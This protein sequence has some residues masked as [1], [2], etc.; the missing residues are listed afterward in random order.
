[1]VMNEEK[2]VK[3]IL[4]AFVKD[5][6]PEYIYE[7][8]QELASKEDLKLNLKQHSDYLELSGQVQAEDFQIYQTEI[9]LN[10]ELESVNY[11]CNCPESFAGIC[12]HVGATLIKYLHSLEQE[13][14]E[15]E[16]ILVST[17]WKTT[18]KSYFATQLEP[19][20]GQHYIVY[21][22]FPEVGRLQ[23]EFFRA[24]QNKSGLSSVLNPIT[25]EQILR[26]PEWC[27]VSPDLPQVAEQIGQ[28][29]DY[30]G[31]K[32]EIP[33]GLMSWF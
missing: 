12:K 7:N 13:N 25:L 29:L 5:N 30:Y 24:R 21:R 3:D 32:V 20:P 16:A 33:Y 11:Y 17:D 10:L 28:Y 22:F 18:F 14:S 15:E 6:I 2:K 4:A 23:V 1:M 19:E 8:A 9:S 27:E 26:N 31:H